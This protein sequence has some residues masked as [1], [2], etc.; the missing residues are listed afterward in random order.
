MKEAI[1]INTIISC[2]TIAIIIGVIDIIY[3]TVKIIKEL[4]K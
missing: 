3:L 4:R 1:L 2:F